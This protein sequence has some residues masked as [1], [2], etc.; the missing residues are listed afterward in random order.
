MMLKLVYGVS[1]YGALPLELTS[2]Q[3]FLDNWHK[4]K[5]GIH[6]FQFPFSPL[7]GIGNLQISPS[8]RELGAGYLEYSL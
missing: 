3:C 4:I 7:Y 5:V 1:V 2:S 8:L 6:P